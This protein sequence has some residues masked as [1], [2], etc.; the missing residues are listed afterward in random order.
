MFHDVPESQWHDFAALL[1]HVKAHF[2]LIDPADAAR[3]LTGG[4]P[5]GS[6]EMDRAPCL[7][8]FDDGFASNLALARSIL[9]DHG[10]KALF[11]VCP[12]LVDLP[13][14]AQRDAVVVNILGGTS[15]GAMAPDQPLMNWDALAELRDLGHA[16]GAH[17]LNHRRLAELRGAELTDEIQAPGRILADR[18]GID[19]HWFAYPF[20]DIGA[21]DGEALKVIGRHYRFCRSGVRGFN[22]TGA[23]RLAVLADNIDLS[24]SRPWQKLVLEGGLDFRYRTARQRLDMLAR[25]GDHNTPP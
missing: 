15:A 3:R 1:I 4:E 6:T 23:H 14:D 5:A 7:L 18:L 16:I 10:A 11:F 2:G 22:R 9:P 20:G 13:A 17:G 25:A 19:V 8:S 24:A 21:I 12:G